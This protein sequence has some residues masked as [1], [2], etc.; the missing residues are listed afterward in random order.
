VCVSKEGR[1]TIG[2]KT[3]AYSTLMVCHALRSVLVRGLK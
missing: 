1:L 3:Y 2:T